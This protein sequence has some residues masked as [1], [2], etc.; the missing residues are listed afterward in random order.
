MND[1]LHGYPAHQEGHK[2]QPF[3][4]GECRTVS[5][6]FAL[7]PFSI[8]VNGSYSLLEKMG[9]SVGRMNEHSEVQRDRLLDLE[10]SEKE[11]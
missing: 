3:V 7:E 8:F 10:P 5:W 6:A 11:E 2:E 1:A 9:T 4:L